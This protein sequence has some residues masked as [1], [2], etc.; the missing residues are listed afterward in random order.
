[1]IFETS[2]YSWGFTPSSLLIRK[3]YHAMKLPRFRPLSAVGLVSSVIVLMAQSAVG[4]ENFES[5]QVV[6][7]SVPEYPVRLAY[8]G[9]YSGGARLIVGIDETGEL[10]DVFV[11]SY[12][13]SEFG[14]LAERYIQRWTFLPAKLNGEPI[15][16]IKPIDFHFDDKRG[17]YSVGG[18]ESLTALLYTGN[19]QDAKRTYS[20]GDLDKELEPIEIPAPLYPEDL[21][22]SG[23]DGSATLMFYVD[24]RGRVRMPHVTE[25]SQNIFGESAL[26]SV[27]QWR[28]ESPVIDGKKV[29]V[30]VKQRFDFKGAS[31]ES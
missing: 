24:E 5:A 3:P 18:P 10:T 8:E 29:S 22:H 4:V 2:K 30:L 11:E 27:K 12:S 16:S 28:F 26:H 25:Y 21:K 14:R 6:D 20:P 7:T 1:M 15:T 13:H 31:G 19:N 23:V 17:V 9:I